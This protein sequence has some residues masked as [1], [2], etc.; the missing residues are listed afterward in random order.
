MLVRGS[1][2]HD[3]VQLP[4]GPKQIARPPVH[5][6]GGVLLHCRTAALSRLPVCE[7]EENVATT[8][9]PTR[10]F[11]V[12]LLAPSAAQSYLESIAFTIWLRSLLSQ[13]QRQTTGARV[14]VQVCRY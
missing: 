7:A 9:Q 2:G 10:A 13:Q 14:G 8:W 3:A 1:N 4:F 5:I 6:P 12:S 11:K